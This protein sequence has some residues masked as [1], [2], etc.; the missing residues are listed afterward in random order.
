MVSRH[1]SDT[2]RNCVAVQE[3]TDRI[4]TCFRANVGLGPAHLVRQMVLWILVCLCAMLITH[5]VWTSQFAYAHSVA[6]P[7][8]LYIAVT[9]AG[10]TIDITYA[11]QPGREARQ[12]R[13][14]ADTND[15]GKLQK[16]EV[17]DLSAKLT[18]ESTFALD[19]TCNE[20]TIPAYSTEFV[21][22]HGVEQPTL[23][24]ADLHISARQ[25]YNVNWSSKETT[26]VLKDRHKNP[27]WPVWAIL[28]PKAEKLMVI[29]ESGEER[30]ESPRLLR[31][32]HPRGLSL[33]ISTSQRKGK[34]RSKHQ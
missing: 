2:L 32:D 10:L 16:N 21:A 8:T 15:D 26:C 4:P 23:S 31:V 6:I 33:R 18:V 5:G 11:L 28:S 29:A 1:E 9:P 13:E 19:L 22:I 25:I 14:E 24:A 27:K 20:K 17:D 30:G 34:P 3:Y 7:K 12:C